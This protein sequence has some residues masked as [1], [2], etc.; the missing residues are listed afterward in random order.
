MTMNETDSSDARRG[1]NVA[2]SGAPESTQ[3]APTKWSLKRLLGLGACCAAPLLGG[4]ALAGGGGALLGAA[5]AIL[6][7]LA[8]LACPLGMYFMMRSM[9]KRGHVDQ[10]R[11]TD[12]EKPSPEP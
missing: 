6:P 11:D 2:E 10:S 5:G 8:A 1:M 3:A 9:S 4:V 12:R 7:F